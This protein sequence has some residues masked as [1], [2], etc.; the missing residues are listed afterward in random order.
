MLH[1][2]ADRSTRAAVTG[3]AL[4]RSRL[5]KEQA[6]WQPL[7]CCRRIG[8]LIVHLAQLNAGYVIRD[9]TPQYDTTTRQLTVRLLIMFVS[10]NVHRCVVCEFL[11][12]CAMW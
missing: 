2:V 5:N 10:T 12:P 1:A 7:V 6:G 9:G 3:K 4:S 8:P 11:H